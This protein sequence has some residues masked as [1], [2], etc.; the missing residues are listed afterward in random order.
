[1]RSAFIGQT[2]TSYFLHIPKT[3]CYAKLLFINCVFVIDLV[4]GLAHLKINSS[5]EEYLDFE[6]TSDIRSEYLDGYIYAMAGESTAHSQITVNLIREISLQ[7]KKTSC[8]VFSP[9]MK[10][11]TATKSLFSYP[12][13]TIVCGE[14]IFHDTKKDVLINPKVIIEVLSPS[15]EKYDRVEKFMRYRTELS[16][17]TDYILV[18]QEL[19]LIE[20]FTHEEN[21]KWTHYF[22]E[23]LTGNIIIS[24]IGC[25]L[26]L[27]EIYDRVKF[28]FRNEEE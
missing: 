10:V 20:H 9:N 24:T 13:V 1:M 8:Q 28:P 18:S 22:G 3:I 6:R 26:S 23:S 2:V 11:R 21:G 7:L 5:P 25:A 15:T 27:A 4:M 19:P 14:P 16:S 17:L 12:D